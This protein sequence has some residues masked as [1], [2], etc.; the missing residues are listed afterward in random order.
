[1]PGCSLQPGRNGLSPATP[2]PYCLS[3]PTLTWIRSA[4]LL[5]NVDTPGAA[6]PERRK[7]RPKNGL[8]QAGA[9]RYA[10]F[11][12][13]YLGSIG[14]PCDR[15][16]ARKTLVDV[17]GGDVKFHAVLAGLVRAI[18]HTKGRLNLSILSEKTH[19]GLP[20]LGKVHFLV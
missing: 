4:A 10:A 11:L 1:M 14:S 13:K 8:F 7:L 18:G 3:R 5:K 12:T 20:R 17:V 2:S 6:T 9:T 19:N 15:Y 16:H